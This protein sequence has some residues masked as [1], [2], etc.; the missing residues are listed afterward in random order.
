MVQVSAEEAKS[1]LPDLIHAAIQG[2]E[3]YI[4]ENGGPKVRLV[5]VDS[6]ERRPRFGSARGLIDVSDDF[7][8]PLED[9]KEYMP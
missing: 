2:E 6:G 3:V 4:V 5:P 7:D 8:E 1:K 9:F